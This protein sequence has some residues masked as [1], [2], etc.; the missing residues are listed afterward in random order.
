MRTEDRINVNIEE[1]EN[2]QRDT[3]VV[4]EKVDIDKQES[5]LDNNEETITIKNGETEATQGKNLEEANI[6]KDDQKESNNKEQTEFLFNPSKEKYIEIFE[7]KVS[8]V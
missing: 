2:N 5:V 4:E 7:N 8:L 3:I 1:I 6:I